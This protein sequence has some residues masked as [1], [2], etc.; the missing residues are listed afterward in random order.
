MVEGMQ[1]GMPPPI[2]HVLNFLF[3]F[4]K[5]NM[6]VRNR[7]ELFRF[8]SHRAAEEATYASLAQVGRG[9]VIDYVSWSLQAKMSTWGELPQR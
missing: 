2:R 1:R 9:V 5:E 4:R 6:N 7:C 8:P 3:G